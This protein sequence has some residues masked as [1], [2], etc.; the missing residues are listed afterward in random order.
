[1]GDEELTV[2]SR[3][4]RTTRRAQRGSCIMH[5]G[6]RKDRGRDRKEAER[7]REETKRENDRRDRGRHTPCWQRKWR[8]L[9]E[10][11]ERRRSCESRQPL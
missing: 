3:R 10:R 1:M 6:S 2:D 5:D 11:Q 7:K 9:H 4:R 8:R